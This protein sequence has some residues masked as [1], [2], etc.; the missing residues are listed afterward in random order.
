MKFKR[1]LLAGFVLS[2][3]AGC[4]G[5]LEISIEQT[6]PSSQLPTPGN[7]TPTPRQS[8][9][10]VP[11]LTIFPPEV[12]TRLLS[13]IVY[14]A[15]DRLWQ[16]AADGWS[17]QILDSFGRFLGLP[18]LSPDGDYVLYEKHDASNT[19]LWLADL[20]TGE[21]RNLTQTPDR[22]ESNARWWAAQPDVIVCS[23]RPHEIEPG[24][25]VN[26]FLTIVDA[27]GNNYHVLDDQHDTGGPPA[28]SPDG[29]MIAYGQ[30]DTGWLYHWESVE[31]TRR[32]HP[33]DPADYE[34]IG[35]DKNNITIDSPAWSPDGT[36]LA[37]FINGDFAAGNPQ[38]MGVGVFD[39]ETKTARVLHP[40]EPA[41]LGGD[42]YPSP[43]WSP[44]GEWLAFTIRSSNSAE[45]GMWIVNVGGQPEIEYYLDQC[46]NAVWSPDGRRLA[47]VLPR[48]YAGGEVRLIEMDTGDLESLNLPSDIYLVGWIIPHS[49]IE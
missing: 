14:R 37:W 27:Q 4:G 26:G 11:T 25:G 15:D 45:T 10:P 22:S 30:G 24:P 9:I 21:R 46:T 34:L 19:D 42:S 39:L 40:Y 44:D 43:I 49:V 18:S 28:L 5:T 35:Y 16:I 7:V 31:V 1:L 20:T 38:Q 33:F 47:C 13:E 23:S 8:Q 2:L 48:Q 36:R 3:L 32:L 17:V 6:A 41:Y 12:S 29:Q